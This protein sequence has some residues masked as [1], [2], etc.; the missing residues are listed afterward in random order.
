[1]FTSPP[2]SIVILIHE[3][4][5]GKIYTIGLPFP[6][7]PVMLSLPPSL[8]L[9]VPPLT[10]KVAEAQLL[11]QCYATGQW[12]L[13][14]NVLGNGVPLHWSGRETLPTTPHSL[15]SKSIPLTRVWLSQCPCDW[16]H[17][18]ELDIACGPLHFRILFTW[19]KRV[20][21]FAVNVL[22]LT[23]HPTSDYKVNISLKAYIC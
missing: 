13:G 11:R 22:P 2:I 4:I 3:E 15:A 20:D 19:V 1:M 5:Q 9:K 23:I 6:F 14:K 18:W 7:S 10:V 17:V 21:C 12:P 8:L 16:S